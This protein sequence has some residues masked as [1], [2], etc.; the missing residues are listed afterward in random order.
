MLNNGAPDNDNDAC[1]EKEFNFLHNINK[2]EAKGILFDKPEGTWI[3]YYTK[4]TQER[5]AFKTKDK[6]K[7]ME[8]ISKPS[9]F[10]FNEDEDPVKLEELIYRLQG[11]GFLKQQLSHFENEESDEEEN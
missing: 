4:D 3:L 10:T 2:T 1:D 6:V 7:Q 11:Q 9:G 8:I 5:I